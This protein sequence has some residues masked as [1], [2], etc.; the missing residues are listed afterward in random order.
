MRQHGDHWVAYYADADTMEGALW[1]GEIHMGIA[2]EE[3]YKQRF[4]D[5]MQDVVGDFIEEKTGTRPEWNDPIPGP[6]DER[7]RRRSEEP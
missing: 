6:E 7:W 2:N 3:D 1:L 4:L 5:L